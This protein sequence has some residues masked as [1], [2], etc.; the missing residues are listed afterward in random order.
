MNRIRITTMILAIAMTASLPGGAIAQA[1]PAG[2]EGTD[3]ALTSYATGDGMSSVP[4]AV[5]ATLHLEDGQA[6]GS[7]GC[8]AFSGS[9]QLDGASLTFSDELTRTLAIC[10]DEV[11]AVEDAYLTALPEVTGWAIVA[12]V[13]ELSDA[14]GDTILTFEVPG[15][16]LTSSDLAAL[17]QTLAGLQTEIDDLRRD[18]RRLNVDKLRERIKVL[19]ADSKKLKDQLATAE[20]AA[21]ATSAPTAFSSAEKILLQGIPPRIGSRCAPLRSSL[22][23]GTTAAVRCRPNTTAVN[24][25]DYHL[26]EGEDAAKV[27]GDTM[28]TFNV[29]KATAESETCENGTKSQ[30]VWVGN[31]WEADGCY[32]AGGRAEIHFVD[33][34]T[35]CKQL[36]VGGKRIKSPALYIAVQG[37]DTDVARVHEWA[38]RGIT[39]AS[40]RVTS[41]SQT[42][43]RP[44]E[45]DSPSC[46]I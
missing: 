28:T 43:E 2:P 44:N 22:P 16:G 39:H 23:K 42:I 10:E 1:A 36:K 14:F 27:F 11:Q 26:M 9:Y 21:T 32:R 37:S 24:S 8:N 41:I 38:T 12:D 5:D 13:L 46:P 17:M 25:V 34:A 15:V 33:N 7:G 30:R 20:K 18:M 35:D 40:P 3:W 45:K 31:G 4:F 19:E 6:S 29:P